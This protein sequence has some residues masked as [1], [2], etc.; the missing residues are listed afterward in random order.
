MG[1]DTWILRYVLTLR[2]IR[3]E[4]KSSNLIKSEE[5]SKIYSIEDRTASRI[6]NY[7]NFN[8]MYRCCINLLNTRFYQVNELL[9]S[10]SGDLSL[11]ALT[12]W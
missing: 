2:R 12:A 7:S 11:C 8:Y 4:I 10:G 9:T 5:R 3:R 1:G 6:W